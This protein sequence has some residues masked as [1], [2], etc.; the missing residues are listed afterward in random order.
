MRRLDSLDGLR[1]LAV[2]LVLASRINLR[3]IVGGFTGVEVFFAPSGYLITYL[4]LRE[5]Q[6]NGDVNLRKFYARR[7]LRLW[8][9]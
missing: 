9:P 6:L 3:R 7:A 1:A 8:P 2:P 4:L 5:R